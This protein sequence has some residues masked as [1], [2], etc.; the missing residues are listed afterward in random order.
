MRWGQYVNEVDERALPIPPPRTRTGFTALLR[1]LK[2]GESSLL[3]TL[4]YKAHTVAYRVFGKG[5]YRGRKE[6]G[7][8]RIWR[9]A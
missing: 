7:G 8:I 5:N 4:D 1:T 9:I 2:V 6:K 3:P